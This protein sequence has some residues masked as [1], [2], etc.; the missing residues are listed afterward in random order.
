M[1]ELLLKKLDELNIKEIKEFINAYNN[2]NGLKFNDP[3][4]LSKFKETKKCS[5]PIDSE[6]AKNFNTSIG[7]GNNGLIFTNDDKS[8][9]YKESFREDFDI[10]KLEIFKGLNIP[11]IVFPNNLV[12]HIDTSNRIVLRGYIAKYIKSLNIYDLG[13]ELSIAD[14]KKAILIASQNLLELSKQG[15]IVKD[16]HD[17][18]YLF[19][20]NEKVFKFIDTDS[21]EIGKVE[22]LTL[23]QNDF[24]RSLFSLHNNE[25][26]SENNVFDIGDLNEFYKNFIM[27]KMT[28]LEFLEYYII[29]LEKYYEKSI[30]TFSDYQECSIKLLK[31]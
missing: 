4:I 11:N 9:I 5:E 13:G 20:M 21:Y 26:Y 14:Y 30:V 28:L 3:L 2:K 6:I 17:E 1:N 12:Y 18:N 19:D 24:E 22:D 31:K 7:Y 27:N 15:I 23:L 25:G 29:Y 8:L 10:D 16:L